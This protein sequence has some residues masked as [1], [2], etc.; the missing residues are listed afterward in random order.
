MLRLVFPLSCVNERSWQASRSCPSYSTL[1]MVKSH[2]RFMQP[3]ITLLFCLL[4]SHR[5]V[6]AQ[7]ADTTAV[8]W[9]PRP[10]QSNSEAS[11]QVQK[12]TALQQG[13]RRLLLRLRVAVDDDEYGMHPLQGSDPSIADGKGSAE[14]K[15]TKIMTEK[16][17]NKSRSSPASPVTAPEKREKK[18]RTHGN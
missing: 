15:R 2:R 5:T 9:P 1:F 14:R 8:A 4:L 3:S 11:F 7:R 13:H 12:T 16:A 6:H 18:K 17:K 10:Y